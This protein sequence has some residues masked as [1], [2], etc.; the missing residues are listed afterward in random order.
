MPSPS[1]NAGA[2]G[3]AARPPGNLS[4]PAAS[5]A[6]HHVAQALEQRSPGQ[7]VHAQPVAARLIAGR[8]S[9]FERTAL[10]KMP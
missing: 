8:L 10:N 6:A 7:L 4:I 3:T 2:A 9:T 5:P 1:A